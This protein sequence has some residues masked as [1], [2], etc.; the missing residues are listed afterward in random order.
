VNATELLEA[1][2]DYRPTNVEAVRT[3]TQHTVYNCDDRFFVKIGS[4][5]NFELERN[6]HEL[7]ASVGVPVP[8]VVAV[9]DGFLISRAVGGVLL[10]E[11]VDRPA[12]EEAGRYLHAIH[13]VAR[14][15]FGWP[16]GSEIRG[17]YG[18]WGDHVAAELEWSI[19]VIRDLVDIDVVLR[20]FERRREDIDAIAVGRFLHGDLS[21]WNI[22]VDPSIGVITSVIDWADAMVGDPVWDIAVFTS[23]MP[24]VTDALLVGYA[25]E[26][27]ERFDSLLGFY[28]TLRHMWGYRAGIEDGWEESLRIPILHKLIDEL[29]REG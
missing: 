15:G 27:R 19:E 10:S 4:R 23:W 29:R 28:R 20:A 26:S 13:D 6:A 18:T 11:A 7:A 17:S 21:A 22:L 25:P 5:D 14:T 16:D 1:H 9:G 2:A 12:I 3:A 8:E 24:D